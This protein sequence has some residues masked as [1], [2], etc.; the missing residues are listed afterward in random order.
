M[1]NQ[2]KLLAKAIAL[3]AMEHE[4]QL[5]RGGYPYILHCMTVM[6]K[7][8][9]S[10]P[11]VKQIAIMHDLMEDTSVNAALLHSLGFSSRVLTALQLLTHNKGDSYQEYID[12]IA[13]CRDAIL[14]KLADL[15]HNSDFTRLK[16]VTEKDL[17]RMQKYQKAY[18]QLKGALGK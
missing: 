11:E 1:R 3:A 4:G 18:V 6:H 5:D 15:R 10:E 2:Q 9:S 8:K 16:G 12:G 17:A 14:V 13:T 7:V